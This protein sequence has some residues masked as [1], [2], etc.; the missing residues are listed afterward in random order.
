MTLES[1]TKIQSIGSSTI[2]FDGGERTPEKMKEIFDEVVRYIK[3]NMFILNTFAKDT[4]LSYKIPGE[5]PTFAINLDKGEIH[6]PVQWF[7]E[8]EYKK[9]QIL[10]ACLHEISHFRE[11][12]D[13]LEGERQMKEHILEK[14]KEAS[15]WMEEKYREKYE[16]THPDY[17]EGLLKRKKNEQIGEV[18]QLEIACYKY[19]FTLY[20][21]LR[22]VFVNSNVS[23]MVAIYDA[24]EDGGQQVVDLYKRLFPEDLRFSAQSPEMEELGLEPKVQPKHMQFIFKIIRDEMI[25]EEQAVVSDEVQKAFLKKYFYKGKSIT[26]QDFLDTFIKPRRNRDTKLSKRLEASIKVIE[27]IFDNFLYEDIMEIKLP[28]LLPPPEKGE[29]GEPGDDNKE[30]DSENES[31]DNDQEG[32]EGKENKEK[33]DSE[34]S[35]EGG[36]GKSGEEENDDE[37]EG[38]GGG[39]ESENEDDTEGS[40]GEGES[41]D[42]EEGE[43][44]KDA[45]DSKEGENKEKPKKKKDQKENKEKDSSPKNKEKQEN[46]PSKEKPKTFSS[47]PFEEFYEKYDENE[48][49][50]IDPKALEEYVQK[51]RE[52]IEEQKKDSEEKTSEQIAQQIQNDIEREFLEQ[53]KIPKHVFDSFKR[54]QEE[55]SPYLEEL[56]QL[57]E[58]IIYGSTKGIN[59]DIEGHFK[60]GEYL[61][62]KK[63]VKDFPAI[64]RGNFDAVKPYKKRVESMSAI[65][66]PELIRI[67]LVGDTSGSMSGKK[68]EVLR[69]IFVLVL[70]SLFEFEKKL[71]AFR[72]QT[73]SKTRVSTEAWGF[74]DSSSLLKKQREDSGLEEQKSVIEAFERLVPTG[75]TVNS[76]V[77]FNIADSLPPKEKTDV[78]EKKILDI[79]LEITDGVPDFRDI[80][81]T[82]EAIKKLDDQGQ[83]IRSFYIGDDPYEMETFNQIWNFDSDNQKGEIVGYDMKKLIPAIINALKEYLSDVRI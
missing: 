27:P 22:D 39:G 14:A 11:M 10:W 36:N 5:A 49:D 3:E 64:S 80:G 72:S 70:S 73:K 67:R 42:K 32:G 12:I 23:R 33:D 7:L 15:V 26:I 31:D 50:K 78:K 62:I 38:D 48:I 58:K 52:L 66:K 6:V 34:E 35:D 56:S 45:D 9:E 69:K 1:F 54:I 60:E 51:I 68:I 37:K 44:E 43:D 13:D 65:E 8:K 71:E 77:L 25:K 17:I 75:G 2:G 30:N 24:D 74:S 79:V 18:N 63:V 53:T 81:R 41:E 21:V 29:P 55:V 46:V 4:S 20:N 57:W 40:D 82:V 28:D 83:I 19:Y 76:N 61:D 59:Y 47:I 16:S